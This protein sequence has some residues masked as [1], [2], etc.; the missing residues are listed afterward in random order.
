MKEEYITP[1]VNVNYY[2]PVPVF[3]DPSNGDG[4]ENAGTEENVGGNG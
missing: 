3:T 1:E 4:L 2:D